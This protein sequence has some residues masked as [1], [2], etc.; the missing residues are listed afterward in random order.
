MSVSSGK[1]SQPPQ[2][3]E[4]TVNT[5]ETPVTEPLITTTADAAVAVIVPHA[6]EEILENVALLTAAAA[7]THRRGDV[8]RIYI[9]APELSAEMAEATVTLAK[10]GA[11]VKVAAGT[12]I[13]KSR[14]AEDG[15]LVWDRRESCIDRADPEGDGGR[16][17][18]G[19]GLPAVTMV[20][21]AL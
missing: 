5:V 7:E 17:K 1:K 20:T 3:K 15:A 12:A 21:V 4:T 2:E 14:T 11:R 6:N 9:P 10:L 18:F 8:V 16:R 13:Y 19:R